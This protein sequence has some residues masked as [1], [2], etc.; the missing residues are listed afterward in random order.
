MAFSPTIGKQ[1]AFPRK[2]FTT[3]RRIAIISL[4][5]CVSLSAAQAQ[6]PKENLEKAVEIFNAASEY[7]DAL[8]AKTI[9]D[10]QVGV[11]KSRMDKG[12]L[13]LENV[14]KEGNADEH[15]HIADACGHEGFHCRVTCGW[16]AIPETYQQVG[17]Q[18]HDL[19]TH[20][21]CEQVVGDD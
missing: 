19:P 2:N 17:A 16:L 3:M 21:E 7:Q 1:F 6:T 14:I 5:C 12:I 20:K 9:T 8:N 13:L 10:E 4:F 11:V 18:A 15:E